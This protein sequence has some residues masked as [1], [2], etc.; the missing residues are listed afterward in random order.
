MKH[1]PVKSFCIDGSDCPPALRA[2]VREIQQEFPKRFGGRGGCAITFRQDPAIK[3]GGLAISRTPQG[4]LIR[5]GRTV[6]A[7]RALGSVM[8][9][10]PGLEAFKD[11]G[12]TPPFDTLGVMWDVSRNGVLLPQAARALIR[13]LALMGINTLM[14]YAEDVYDVPGEPFFGYLRG[15]YS[16]AELKALDRYAAHFGIEMFPCIQT[17]GHFEQVLK[18]PAYRDLT[19]VHG[20]LTVGD[21]ATY[22]LLEKIIRAAS[23]PFRSRRIHIGM[24]EAHGLGSGRYKRLHG[25]RDPFDI[26]SDHL[27]RVCGI[28]H[29]V[30][31]SPMIWCDMYFRMASAHYDYFDTTFT[32][33][34]RV[35]RRIPKDVQLVYWDYY[36]THEG[37]YRDFIDRHRLLGVEPIVAGGL[38]TWCRFW[39]QLPYAF[40]ATDACMRACKAKGVREAFT[41]LWFDDGNDCDPFSALPGIQYFAEHGYATTPDSKRLR[42][43]FRGSCDA[44]FDAWVQ[45]GSMDC[46]GPLTPADPPP[47]SVTRAILW[48]D[49]LIGLM[50]AQLDGFPRRDHYEKMANQLDQAAEGGSVWAQRLRFPAAVARA[51]GLKHRLRRNLLVAYRRKDR[52]QLQHLIQC[53]LPAVRVAVER[54]WKEHRRLWTATY[55]P[56]GF[57]VVEGRYGALLARLDHLNE[58]LD[59]YANGHVDS[60][61]ELDARHRRVR[62][63]YKLGYHPDITYGTVATASCSR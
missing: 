4:V 53:D 10:G 15:G 52:S 44:D 59:A 12:E 32:F 60:I 40:L 36:H 9:T 22:T 46:A 29:K 3:A 6:D 11:Y 43:N 47:L 27:D 56:F 45:A 7:F 31:L 20:V 24:D 41:T 25:D 62:A 61:P 51:A 33:P 5:Y 57:E 50:D 42:T 1:E 39:A 19:D 17:L 63:K 38:W 28:C 34:K 30:G 26:F 37:F 55:K 35:K 13:R 49:P 2:G 21:E 8:G 16:H 54:L 18:W 58:R 48:D 14:L 23:A